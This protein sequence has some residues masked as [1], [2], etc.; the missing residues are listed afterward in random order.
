MD[1]IGILGVERRV[2]SL[3]II[4][5]FAIVFSAGCC[6]MLEDLNNYNES[7]STD[8][9]NWEIFQENLPGGIYGTVTNLENSAL[10]N[11]SVALTGNASNYSDL[12]DANGKYNVSGVPAGSYRIIVSKAGYE[13]VTFANL[14]IVAGYPYPWNVPLASSTG[15]FHGTIK[16]LKNASMENANISIFNDAQS[17][18]GMSD[19]NGNYS[20]AGI[21]PNVYNILVQ[22]P[23]YR[24][25]TLSNF[26]ILN[27][28]YAWNATVS[29]DCT[30][31]AE[32][33][34][35]NYALKYGFN[36]MLYHGQR[37]FILAYP[38][39]ATYDIYPTADNG[40]SEISTAY[41]AGNRMLKWHLDNSDGSYS[42]VEGHIFI[43]MN[44]TGTMQIYDRK[45][46]SI[47]EASSSQPSYLGSETTESGKAMI[48]PSNSEIS[49]IAQRVKSETRSDDTWTVAKALF[50][51]LK[52]NTVY[53][54][55]PETS[56]YSNSAIDTLHSGKGK[57]DELSHLYISMLRAD[58]IPARFVKGY[59]AEKN[60]GMYISHRWVEFYDGEW[61]P[62]EVAG[63][64]TNA[65]KEADTFF[66]IQLSNHVQVFVDDGT[67]ESV[68]EKAAGTGTY[69]DR[70]DV[71]T[72][73]IFYDAIDYNQKYLAVCSDGTRELK[74]D[75]E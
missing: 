75:R 38:E 32:N 25:V 27:K 29:R 31:Y 24:N 72:S 23:G 35:T 58:G 4:L 44:G 10:E 33:T 43:N 1:S 74:D 13:N 21:E 64:S 60:P 7:I 69:Y 8:A 53:Y 73:Y 70:P 6:G 61:V 22:K 45:E 39:G 37:Y 52:N 54:I 66:G 20:I 14:T 59:V 2:S 48:D 46:M 55:N 28:P 15:S 18:S 56:D 5:L 19:E 26:T 47:S 36:E 9:E 57:C 62:V 12:T 11:A 42:Y 16:N 50:I 51:W 40:F 30:Y 49:A 67:D 34:S 17:Y 3:A 71:F 65:S 41:Q 68:S 63:N